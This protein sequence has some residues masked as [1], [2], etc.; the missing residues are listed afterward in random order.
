MKELNAHTLSPALSKTCRLFSARCSVWLLSSVASLLLTSMA[1]RHWKDNKFLRMHARAYAYL[2]ASFCKSLYPIFKLV[3]W[4]C[5]LYETI[6]YECFKMYSCNTYKQADPV[7]LQ[8]ELRYGT[9]GT[10][11]IKLAQLRWLAEVVQLV[12]HWG[13]IVKHISQAWEWPNDHY[14]F[15]HTLSCF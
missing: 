8:Q 10:W 6:T 9:K 11:T 2:I 5:K 15:C 7:I 3:F 1:Y 4:A 14:K 13:Q 12:E